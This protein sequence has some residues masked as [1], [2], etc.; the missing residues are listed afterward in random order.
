[1]QNGQCH[2]IVKEKMSKKLVVDV[3][4]LMAREPVGGA[5][6]LSKTVNSSSSPMSGTKISA[7]S[8]LI[9]DLSVSRTGNI[10]ILYDPQY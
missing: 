3:L 7:G 1:M 8:F 6:K 5:I 10:D 2:K 9:P 4:D